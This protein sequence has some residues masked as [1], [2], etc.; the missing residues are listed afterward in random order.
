AQMPPAQQP[1][2][3]AGRSRRL[4]ALP[5]PADR[6]GTPR[7]AAGTGAGG[8]AEPAQ[9]RAADRQAARPGAS[10]R[11]AADAAGGDLSPGLPVALAPGK[12]TRLGG[13]EAG[14]SPARRW[15]GTDGIMSAVPSGA[16][17]SI[18]PMREADVEAVIE[19]ER[20]A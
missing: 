18:R 4:R 20:R 5:A 14:Q 3:A 15:S 17:C 13:F 10:L 12:S 2:S 16:V 7:S 9:D 1:R 6:A 11:A 8:G 19:I